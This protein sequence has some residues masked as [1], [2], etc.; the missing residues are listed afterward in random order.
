MLT[1]LSAGKLSAAVV[2]AVCGG[3]VVLVC[4]AC[5]QLVCMHFGSWD[6]AKEWT[7]PMPS[8]EDIQVQA[9]YL[10]S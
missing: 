2:D 7:M 10:S 3:V 1:T 8:G 4:V 6:N 5:S 9:C